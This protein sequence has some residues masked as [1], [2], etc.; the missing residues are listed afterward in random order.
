MTFKLDT[1]AVLEHYVSPLLYLDTGGIYSFGTSDLAVGSKQ[2]RLNEIMDLSA[3]LCITVAKT[4]ELAEAQQ[5]PVQ[6][7][8]L[9]VLVQLE[10]AFLIPG[11][12][13]R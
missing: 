6:D 9:F 2:L 12:A 3:Q 13:D 7:T 10:T 4:W 1:V 8:S 11:R 5:A